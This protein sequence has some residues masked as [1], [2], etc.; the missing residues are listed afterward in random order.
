MGAWYLI[1]AFRRFGLRD[2][3]RAMRRAVRSQ[4]DLMFASG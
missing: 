2:A 3:Q 4:R 1:R